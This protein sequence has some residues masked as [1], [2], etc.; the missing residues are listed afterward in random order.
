MNGTSWRPGQDLLAATRATAA[1]ALASGA[2]APMPARETVVEEA[3]VSFVVRVIEAL[4]KKADARTARPAGFDPFLPYDERLW[5]GDASPSHVLLLNKFPV[6]PDHVL[7]ATRAWEDQDEPLTLADFEAACT[8]MEAMDGLAF[9]NG[10]SGAGASQRHKHLQIVPVPLARGP[11]RTPL[12]PA[13]AA[14]RLPFPCATRPWTGRAEG[15]L[16][17]YRAMRAEVGAD[18]PYNWLA[19]RERAWLVPRVSETWRGV[20]VNALGFAGSLVVR[21]DAELAALAATGPFAVLTS[22]ARSA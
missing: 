13:I 2:L 10:G 21:S 20:S 11:E 18:G 9:Y 5:I 4:A 15:E 19:T 12:D 22:V 6:L 7:I 16:R 1:T 14:G 8:C 3:G 17:S